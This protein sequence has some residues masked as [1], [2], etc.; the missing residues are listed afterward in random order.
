M[1]ISMRG[2]RVR[3]LYAQAKK[4]AEAVLECGR[5][6]LAQKEECAHGEWLP[7]LEANFPGS[8]RAAYNWMQ[9]AAAVD[10]GKIEASGAG[11]KETL[12]TLREN[13]E[14]NLQP[15]QLS[16]DSEQ[17]DEPREWLEEPEEYEDEEDEPEVDIAEPASESRPH[18]SYNSGENE[19]YTPP[20]FI[21]L[22]RDVMGSIDLDPATSAFAQETVLAETYFTKEDD[23]LS[24]PWSGRVW[25]NPPYE[26]GLIDQFI[27]KLA[28]HFEAGN[29]EQFVV[30]VNNATD[31]RW[32]A[33]LLEV[34]SAV[35]FPT[36]RVRFLRP[37]GE[38]GAPLQGQALVYGGPNAE[39]FA[40]VT[41]G[42]GRCLR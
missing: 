28:L 14:R 1:E 4:G 32:F 18:V 10:A 36:G 8:R 20:V 15:L 40:S 19:W 25:M 2:A 31:T 26:K 21:E 29:V 35:V 6:L 13:T 22:A 11:L 5:E 41:H 3:E 39:R 9:V 37:D 24:R 12:E 23:G 38:R 30:L 34:A 16:P 42:I 27:D 17:E 33:R 7:W